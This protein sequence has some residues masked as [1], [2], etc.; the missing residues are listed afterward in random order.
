M[1]HILVLTTDSQIKEKLKFTTARINFS[2]SFISEPD[3]LFNAISL[4]PPSLLIIDTELHGLDPFYSLALLRQKW[5]LPILFLTDTKRTACVLQHLKLDKVSYQARAAASP[6]LAAHIQRTWLKNP[7]PSLPAYES[8]ELC[9]YLD[10]GYAVV[11]GESIKLTSIEAKILTCLLNSLNQTVPYREILA[12]VWGPDHQFQTHYIQTYINRLR[13]KLEID[14]KM[15]RYLQ[16]ERGV[17]YR[18]TNA[19]SK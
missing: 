16:N 18:F 15:P 8:E 1:R 13:D 19:A 17:G 12:A 7:R 10:Q 3:A 6:T 4:S 5:N 14:P 11:Q 2:I 9:L